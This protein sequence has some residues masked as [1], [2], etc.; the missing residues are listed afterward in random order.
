MNLDCVSCNS[1]TKG[2][3]CG[4]QSETMMDVSANKRI[5]SFKK[6]QII[7]NEGATA[8]GL[9][10][11]QNGKVKIVKTNHFGK[12][13]ICQIRSR[14]ELLGHNSL[15]DYTKYLSTAIS[16]ENSKVCFLEKNHI[17]ET[18]QKHP[19]LTIHFI[20]YLSHEMNQTSMKYTSILNK[21][22]R[23][24]LAELLYSLSHSFGTTEDDRIRLDIRLTREEFASMIG[25]VNE[26]VTRFITEFKQE[27]LIEEEGGNIFIVD[28]EKLIKFANIK[29]DSIELYK[30]FS[31]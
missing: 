24:R 19:D 8:N 13:A 5:L 17:I 22:V 21:N 3:F 9:Y 26:T 12:G 10:C 4:L 20:K 7:Y 30:I 18:I 11:V 29:E 23:E 16:L 31:T 28:E 2:F 1:K 6:G 14:G 27:G 15:F 25:T